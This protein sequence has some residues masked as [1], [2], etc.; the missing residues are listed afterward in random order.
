MLKV[1]EKKAAYVQTYDEVKDTVKSY[2]LSNKQMEEWQKF[3]YSLVDA[4][5]IVYTT[6]HLKVHCLTG[7][8]R[9]QTQ[10][11]KQRRSLQRLL[12]SLELQVNNQV[13][14]ERRLKFRQNN[15]QTDLSGNIENIDKISD[16]GELFE[17]LIRVMSVLRSD[18]GCMWDREQTHDTIKRNIVE[19]AYEA[20]ESIEEKDYQGFKRR[21]Q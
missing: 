14:E 11:Q 15:N 16:S 5:K 17:V 13:S 3:V 7:K 10:E 19:E 20:V 18:K 6:M 9:V 12:H 21:T 8:P 4:A 2:L 1:T